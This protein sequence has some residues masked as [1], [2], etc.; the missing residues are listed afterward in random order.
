[1]FTRFTL[2]L[3]FFSPFSFST[4]APWENGLFEADPKL[5]LEAA[6]SFGDGNEGDNVR[7]LL[8]ETLYRINDDGS[9]ERHYR[10]VYRVLNQK[11]VELWSNAEATWAPWHQ[12]RPEINVRIIKPDG[13]TYGLDPEHIVEQSAEDN[14]NIYS[15]A[16]TL[17]APFPNVTIGSVIEEEIIVADHKP[18]FESGTTEARGLSNTYSAVLTRVVIETPKKRSFQYK[19][20]NVPEVEP[21]RK[22]KKGIVI[23]TFNYK[24]LPV[25]EDS[26][27]GQPRTDP[28][29]PALWF[30]TSKSW[31][32]VAK[33]YAILVDRQLD[34]AQL[35]ELPEGTVVPG[36]ARAT[37]V[38]MCHWL[39]ERVRYTGMELGEGSIVPSPP[40]ETL[41]RQY[42][43]CK[44]KATVLIGLLRRAGFSADAS[45]L[46]AA[47][48]T[49]VNPDLPGLG[50]FNHVIVAVGGEH[51][52]FIDPTSEYSREG[53]LPLGDQGIYTLIAN[54]KTRALTR[55]PEPTST[56][57]RIVE[58]RAFNLRAGAKASV[59]EA[60][61]Y[62]GY[63]DA[64]MRRNYLGGVNETVTEN[65]EKY[66]THSYRSGKLTKLDLGEA[67]DFSQPFQVRLEVEDSGRGV[68]D[69]KEAAVGILYDTF[70]GRLPQAFNEVSEE[71]RKTN[72]VFYEPHVYEL[73]HEILPPVGYVPREI[74]EEET[75]ELGSI[76]LK[77]STRIEGEK[78]IVSYVLDTG[79]AVLTPEEFTATAK[80]VTEFREE[81]ARLVYFDHEGVR[82]MAEGN[83]QRSLEVF[84]EIVAAQPDN[85]VQRIRL[86]KALLTAGLGER[87]REVV[88][89]AVALNPESSEA[90]EALGWILQHD[91]I[92]RR[93]QEGFDL[94]GSVAAYEKA[95]E[96]DGERVIPMLDLAILL[97]HGP[98]GLR[99]GPRADLARA[100]ELYN[101]ALAKNDTLNFKTN[102]A[103]DLFYAHRFDEI[104][105]A[106]KGMDETNKLSYRLAA[107]AAKKDVKA[108]EQQARKI[109]PIDKRRKIFNGA[110]E[111]LLKIREYKKCAA[112]LRLS[113]RGSADAM[114]LEYRADIIEKVVAHEQMTHDPND[115]RSVFIQYFLTRLHADPTKTILADLVSEEF[116]AS[117]MD[118]DN[119]V[120]FLNSRRAIIASAE[121][122]GLDC[123]LDITISVTTTRVD[124]NKELGYRLIA[125]SG[126]DETLYLL[127][128]TDKGLVLAGGEDNEA[129]AGAQILRYLEAG[130][131]EA[132][133]Q[134]AKWVKE[135]MFPN[136]FA[137]PF[138]KSM[139]YFLRQAVD[140]G[141]VE[142]VGYYAAIMLAGSDQAEKAIKVLRDGRAKAETDEQRNAFDVGLVLAYEGED[143]LAKE[144][145]A[146]TSRLHKAWPDSELTFFQHAMANN[147]FD[148]WSALDELLAARLAKEP[149]NE[150]ALT[151]KLVS[152]VRTSDY[153]AA[154][155]FFT[156]LESKGLATSE[157]F[158]TMAWFDLFL[159]EPTGMALARARTAVNLDK[160]S[161]AKLHTLATLYAEEG[162]CEEARKTL[163]RCMQMNG[164]F[165][166]RS[167]DWFVLGRIAEQYGERGTA[168]K[169]YLKVKKPDHDYEIGESTWLLAQRRLE[170]LKKT[171]EGSAQ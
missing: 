106:T 74:P 152:Y 38:A 79:K 85:P 149:D 15:D 86:A 117:E 71:E 113:A 140:N 73:H 4:Q 26:E 27:D 13:T 94:V 84:R 136:E 89:E 68:V 6:A 116:Y 127:A 56:D 1:M 142:A 98:D 23:Y 125:K 126:E 31:A 121:N 63:Q 157:H 104:E 118:E 107:T 19:T 92:G 32:E 146:T 48:T 65:I 153:K 105:E 171:T 170:K 82:E 77:T 17:K 120:G 145:L 143:H 76:S 95:I 75:I 69:D 115:P 162:R 43:D 114:Q 97:E 59:V 91:P 88:R 61:L 10:L 100:I 147:I 16:K 110:G 87:A 66:V 49:D 11:G 161:W 90:H 78:V 101:Q 134:W 45:L 138:L 57:H 103:A 29:G 20:F 28:R 102:V 160:Q 39:N 5:V 159:P 67:R 96:L 34:G 169:A 50:L 64:R 7:I 130:N 122:T 2:A 41:K 156:D 139:T 30:S 124:G 22:K 135:V 70:F 54:A 8:N 44:D 93:F 141:D 128:S 18:F 33:S 165:S 12:N 151:Q 131:K 164:Q 163:D 72:F 144:I 99:Y 137:E 36:N 112:L 51:P 37:A 155:A 109:H 166:P 58:T 24:N 60:S 80:A 154:D 35:P 158:N 40:Q 83:Y 150:Q 53:L 119:E 129:E 111:L 133:L 21:E 168:V 42:G 123:L 52:F 25:P 46:R 132:A 167:A 47:S 62:Y 55:I 108:A 14:G 81:G 3:F 9:L 148:R